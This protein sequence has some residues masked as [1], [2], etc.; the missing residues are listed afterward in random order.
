MA[1]GPSGAV[2]SN[3]SPKDPLGLVGDFPCGDAA[4]LRTVDFG[5][6][7]VSV[8]FARQKSLKIAGILFLG[9]A[10]GSGAGFLGGLYAAQQAAQFVLHDFASRIVHQADDA[11]D[12]FMVI[13]HAFD[14][15]GP[16]FCSDT[17]LSSM[18]TL[19]Y[20][21][22]AVKDIGRIR[23]G[24]LGCTAVAGRLTNSPVMKP[25]VMVSTLG[26]SI[27]T[28]VSLQMAPGQIGTIVGM[29]SVNI[30][31]SPSLFEGLRREGMD[32][33]VLMVNTRTH[34]MVRIAGDNIPVQPDWVFG[35]RHLRA[36]NQLLLT[37]CSI[38][39]SVCVVTR[40]SNT[41]IRDHNEVLVTSL[42][43]VGAFLGCGFAL[44]IVFA[45]TLRRSLPQQ[46][47][48]AIRKGQLSL[49]YQPIVD[50][51]TSHCV[52]FETLVRWRDRDGLPVAPAIFVAIAEERGFIHELTDWVI[53][54]TFEEMGNA[55]RSRPDLQISI[56]VAP[57]DL[58]GSVLLERLDICVAL[59]GVRPEQIALEI[60]ERSTADLAT[61]SR[62]IQELHAHGYHVHID[63]FGTGFSSLSYLHELTVDA[64]KI[65][66]S[67]TRTAGTDSITATILPQILFIAHSLGLQVIVEGVETESQVEFLRARGQ[68]MRVQGWRFGRPLPVH[69][70]IRYLDQQDQEFFGAPRPRLVQ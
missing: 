65:D 38:K 9:L 1:P 2:N 12:Q 8:A 36:A 40:E 41:L 45:V 48:R 51:E 56:N 30:V 11:A 35:Q 57:S 13:V 46:L 3:A 24:K 62:A 14:H 16:E 26:T 10:L 25:P 68:A 33:M 58:T 5:S 52:G 53:R 6:K 31:L 54:R 17:E 34:Q 60:T 61:A 50:L 7:D 23:D 42:A 4:S 20:R 39:N 55:L 37:R 18:R 70:A 32:F 66:R 27:Y 59:E 63:D 47:R 69:L 15:V 67:F 64:I 43:L 19:L 29:R 22:S 44:A 28:P 49:V 21:S